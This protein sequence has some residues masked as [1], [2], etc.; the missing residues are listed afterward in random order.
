MSRIF[1]LAAIAF[2]LFL[3]AQENPTRIALQTW[4]SGFDRP[5]YATHAG[6]NRLFVVE[7]LGMIK[8]VTD[9][10]TVLATPFLDITDQV[11]SGG[12]EQ[13]LLGLAF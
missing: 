13:G 9:S 7:Q 12:N 6:D 5:V 4:A 3:V 1:S 10:N 11:H 2:P 8:I